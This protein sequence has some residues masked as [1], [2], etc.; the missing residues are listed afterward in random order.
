[1]ARVKEV[2]HANGNAILEEVFAKERE[3]FGDLLNTTKVYA[4]CPPILQA[5][6]MLGKSL[7]DSG[8]LEPQLRAL[9]CMRVAQINGCPF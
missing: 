4:N 1:V 2:E 5:A 8:L 3:T 7:E 9:L 6:K